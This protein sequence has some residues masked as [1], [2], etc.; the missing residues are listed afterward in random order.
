MAQEPALN[1]P[2]LPSTELLDVWKQ[3]REYAQAAAAPNT[4]RA[5][6]SD[7]AD[8]E[9]W[10]AA[11]HFCSL[12]ASGQ[13]LALY[14]TALADRVSVAT[15]ARRQAAIRSVHRAA[16]LGYPSDLGLRRVWAGI[17]RTHGR[18]PATKRALALADLRSIVGGLPAT[19]A[20][21]RDRALLLIGFAGALRRSELIAL[22]VDRPGAGFVRFR[23]VADGLEILIDRSKAD[24][25]GA[26]ATIGIPFGSVPETCAVQAL[27]DW[28]EAAA[29]T[30]GRVFRRIDRWGHIHGGGLSDQSVAQIVKA[31]AARAGMD[32]K[33]LSGH[34][35]RAGL[36]TSAAAN[37]AP[38][39]VIM[40]HMRHARFDTTRRYIR[41]ADRFRRNA[42]KIA[43]L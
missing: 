13:T 23:T 25:D 29:I 6:A 19:L 43:G 40:E 15:I 30:K 28:L 17:R 34:S 9:H 12:P 24:Q 32:P 18:P 1:A 42:A 14:L 35:L 20:G 36:A 41:E 2:P 37:D 16:S 39:H 22:E 10:C 7:W 3:A 33:L 5:Y 21:K 8:F 27:A 4:R 26:G 31:A 38:A 11:H